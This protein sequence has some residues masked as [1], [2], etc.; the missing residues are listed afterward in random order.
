MADQIAT[1]IQWIVDDSTG[2]VT[3]YRRK[4]S[5]V[6]T[7]YP[8][9]TTAIQ[10]SVSGDLTVNSRNGSG[11]VSGYTLGG[12]SYTVTYNS[13]GLPATVSGGGQI[14]TYSYDA[15]GQLTGVVTV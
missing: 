9:S 15:S 3:G 8:L 2:A 4:I 11:L 10:S 12:T 14:Q 5:G 1:G 7:A 6:D 13:F